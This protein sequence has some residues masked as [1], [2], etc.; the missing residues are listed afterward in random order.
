MNAT[1][2]SLQIGLRRGQSY[3]TPIRR[4]SPCS[5]LVI[6]GLVEL[7]VFKEPIFDCRSIDQTFSTDGS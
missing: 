2:P 1:S 7:L 5:R 3:A 6:L 4:R